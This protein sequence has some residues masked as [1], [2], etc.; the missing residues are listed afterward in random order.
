M[1]SKNEAHGKQDSD[2]D[3]DLC[4]GRKIIAFDLFD[5]E[6]RTHFF[7]IAARLMRQI[8]VDEARKRNSA[9]RGGDAIQ[10]SLK[11]ATNM[12]QEHAPMLLLLMML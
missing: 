2:T 8:L 3:C 9:K 1:R 7:G 5:L 10:V 4:P 11:E 12:A 6:N